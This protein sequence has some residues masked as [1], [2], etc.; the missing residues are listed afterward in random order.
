MRIFQIRIGLI[1][2]NRF[3]DAEDAI[4]NDVVD[5]GNDV[6]NDVVELGSGGL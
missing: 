2:T 4:G 1:E 6:G 5:V 3:L